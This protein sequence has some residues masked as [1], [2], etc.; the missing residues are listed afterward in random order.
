MTLALLLQ[1]LAMPFTTP[2]RPI[3]DRL[4]SIRNLTFVL[5]ES[6]RL[7]YSVGMV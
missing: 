5:N 2:Q 1:T 6:D 3:S 7:T 4:V